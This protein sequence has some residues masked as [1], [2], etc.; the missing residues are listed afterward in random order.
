MRHPSRMSTAQCS[1][2]FL[3]C[4]GGAWSTGHDACC[5][6]DGLAVATAVDGAGVFTRCRT[7]I[8]RP[9][10]S[11]IRSRT[12]ATARNTAV[13]AGEPSVS[14]R[15]QTVNEAL[16]EVTKTIK[17]NKKLDVQR[18]SGAVLCF[19]RSPLPCVLT[20]RRFPFHSLGAMQMELDEFKTDQQQPARRDQTVTDDIEYKD[21]FMRV[22]NNSCSPKFLGRAAT[23]RPWRQLMRVDRRIQ[24]LE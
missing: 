10:A 9:F 13:N 3:V 18:K 2:I 24:R 8:I 23:H 22:Q 7:E 5:W 20:H 12:P 15:V 11:P 21:A 17:Y 16:E 4:G 14:K 1:L 6:V 19:H